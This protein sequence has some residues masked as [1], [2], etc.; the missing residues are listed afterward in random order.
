MNSVLVHSVSVAENDGILDSPRPPESLKSDIH[1]NRSTTMFWLAIV[2][3]VGVIGGYCAYGNCRSNVTVVYNNN[4]Y[5]YSTDY[6]YP[7]KNPTIHPTSPSIPTNHSQ[8]GTADNPK[9]KQPSIDITERRTNQASIDPTPIHRRH[10]FL[11]I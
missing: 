6:S 11:S 8:I 7:Y 10:F 9:K 3:L 2:I 4:V 5:H 1:G